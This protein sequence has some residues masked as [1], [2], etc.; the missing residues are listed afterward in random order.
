MNT[1]LPEPA[2]NRCQFQQ[3]LVD[4][5]THKYFCG[6][7]WLSKVYMLRREYSLLNE[8]KLISEM[9]RIFMEFVEEEWERDLHFSYHQ[10][11]HE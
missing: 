7:H 8:I 9:I 4:T 11:T 10:A 1:F 2:L 5:G 3:L 6:V